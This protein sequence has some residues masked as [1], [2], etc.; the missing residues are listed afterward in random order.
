MS[1]DVEC[2]ICYW[3]YNSGRRCPRELRCGHTFCE[4][5]LAT[6]AGDAK[7]VCPLCRHPTAVPGGEVRGLLPVDEAALGRLVSAGVPDAESLSDDEGPESPCQHD[8]DG[9]RAP[10]PRSRSGKVWKSFKRFCNKVIGNE[11]RP[12]CMTNEDMRDIVIM[13]SYL[14]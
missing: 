12:D 13:A 7:V 1:P 9:D 4:S 2:G 14:M 5:C 11:S 8:I 10:S 6:M 3:R